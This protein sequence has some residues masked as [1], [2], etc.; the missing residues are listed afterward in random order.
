MSSQSQRPKGLGKHPRSRICTSIFF[1]LLLFTPKAGADYV[2]IENIGTSPLL[3][4]FFNFDVEPFPAAGSELDFQIFSHR[5]RVDPT[6][7]YFPFA[8][9]ESNP[10][11]VGAQFDTF[12]IPELTGVNYRFIGGNIS[13]FGATFGGSVAPVDVVPDVTVIDF[14]SSSPAVPVAVR[15]TF[16]SGGIPANGVDQIDPSLLSTTE[17]IDFNLVPPGTLTLI[18]GVFSLGGVSFAEHFDGQNVALTGIPGRPFKILSGVP[19]NPLT[20]QPGPTGNNLAIAAFG[21]DPDVGALF[22]RTTGSTGEG[23]IAV[24]FDV[25]QSEVGFDFVGAGGGPA[26]LQFFARDGTPLD[27]VV[28]TSTTGPLDA[29]PVAFRRGGGL[30]DI[31]GFSLHNEDT[32]GLGIDNLRFGADMATVAI[33]VKPQ[34]CPNPLNT[35]SK[36]VIPVAILGN[37]GIDVTQIDPAS[38]RLESVAAIRSWIEDVATPFAP[39]NGLDDAYECNDFGPDGFDDLTL[40]FDTQ[41]LIAALGEVEDGE[42]RILTLSGVLQDGTSIEGQDVVVIKAKGG[43]D[44]SEPLAAAPLSQ[45]GQTRCFDAVAPY[46]EIPCAGTGQDG[47][48][49]A[50]IPIPDPRFTDN[51]DGTV[52][53]RLTGVTWLQ[54][55][56]CFGELSWAAALAAANSLADGQCGLS[57]GS[58]PGDWGLPNIK[59]QLS[60]HDLRFQTITSGAPGAYEPFTN[61]VGTNYWWTSTSAEWDTSRACTVGTEMIDGSCTQ[62][63]D[64][65]TLGYA[66]PVKVNN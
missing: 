46:Q 55:V 29:N 21:S 2:T 33:D 30:A 19:T 57:D 20:L 65:A 38:L 48:F 1:C 40:K 14:V 8:F 66:W 50:G 54:N 6:N 11:P 61:R 36:G 41:E 28:L 58:E 53:D 47:E 60:L 62:P 51:G 63:K 22:G 32:A 18:N 10:L 26:T 64:A 12:L 16:R 31:A 43:G 44:Q 23:S 59:Q 13:T 3:G 39:T 37:A 35:K 9:D 27:V 49:Q 4:M 56:N 45:T 52:T 24:L 5:A 17:L 7:K 34:S 42:V 25:D 15:L